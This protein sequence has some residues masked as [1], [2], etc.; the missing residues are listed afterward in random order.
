MQLKKDIVFSGHVAIGSSRCN[1]G[2][3]LIEVLVSMLIL[4]VGLL[5]IASLQFKGM[6]YST[7]AAIRSNI[8]MLAYDIADRIRLNRGNADDYLGTYTVPLNRPATCTQTNGADASNDLNCWYQLFWVDNDSSHVPPGTVVTI[9]TDVAT[10]E[11]D[12][13]VMFQWTDREN[14]T[15]NIDYVFIP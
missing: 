10:A 2:F 12:Y 6:K 13:S 11:Q 15:R 9:A 7:D 3:T 14:Q 1:A 5:G 8:M 4:A